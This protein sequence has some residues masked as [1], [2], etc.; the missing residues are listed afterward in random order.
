MHVNQFQRKGQSGVTRD[1]IISGVTEQGVQLHD[2][3]L[4]NELTIGKTSTNG[5]R[6]SQDITTFF[7]ADNKPPQTVGEPSERVN[8]DPT[9]DDRVPVSKDELLPK[10]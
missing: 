2:N 5:S 8:T 4:Q 7:Q 1:N 6:T 10:T 3:A 9:E